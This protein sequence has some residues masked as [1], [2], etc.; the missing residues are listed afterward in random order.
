MD[1]RETWNDL[2]STVIN[3]L[4]RVVVFLL[5]LLVGWFIAKAFEKLTNAVLE[6][7]GFDRAVER[8]GIR[9]ALEGSSYDASSIVAKIV[10]FALLLITFMLAFNVFGPN[11][12]SEMLSAVVAWLPQLLIGIVL[13]VV[14]AFIANMV[15]D[16]VGGALGGTSYGRVLATL[17]YVFI[18]GIGVIAA[19][20]QMGIAAAVTGP[21]LFFILAT[22][23]GVIVVGMGGGMIRP[24]QS[25]WEGWLTKAEA[26]ARLQSRTT[27]Y[28]TTGTTDPSTVDVTGTRETHQ[29]PRR[30]HF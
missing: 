17:A 8:G 20:S 15:R 22:I 16:I 24:M 12:V 2:A 11:P 3:I 25:R 28:G 29:T 6:R 10:Y 19:L 9:R 13:I 18:L 1:L 27:P 7:V 26:E 23:G 30:D 14:A 5:I 4:P 21:V